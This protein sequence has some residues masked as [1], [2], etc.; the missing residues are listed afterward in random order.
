M[1][2]F[3]SPICRF[4]L[5]CLH[6]E[7]AISFG[8]AVSFAALCLSE[9]QSLIINGRLLLE[10]GTV[11]EEMLDPLLIKQSVSERITLNSL[12]SSTLRIN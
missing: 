8:R 11:L 9:G 3:P 1:H 12:V 2:L 6:L 5:Q 7:L 4:Y 10:H